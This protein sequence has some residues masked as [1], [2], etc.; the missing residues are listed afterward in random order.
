[1]PPVPLPEPPAPPPPPPVLYQP[2]PSIDCYHCDYRRLPLDAESVDAV[3]TDIPWK[4]PWLRHVPEFAKWCAK[5]LR[6]GGIMAT[7][8]TASNLNRLLAELDNYLEYVWTCFSPMHGSMRLNKPFLTR[9]CTLCVVYSTKTAPPNIHRSPCDLLPYSWREKHP[10][11]EHQQSLPVVQYIVEHFAKEG[12]LV[13]DPCSGGWT[14]AVACWRTGRRFIG[15][16]D[17]IDSK[18]RIVDCLDVARRRFAAE[19]AA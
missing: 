17:G 10:W 5:V 7:L 1:M 11:H 9:C 2:V 12:A 15:S 18:G 16:D 4:E 13:A 6:P 3:I 14:T 19:G 8:Y